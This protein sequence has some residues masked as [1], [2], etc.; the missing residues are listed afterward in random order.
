VDNRNRP[1]ANDV[2]AYL[3]QHPE[4]RDTTEGIADWWLLEQR[5]RSAVAE[6]EAALGALVSQG[7]VVA[8]ECRDGRTY[9]GLN[10][11]KEREVRRY[12]RTVLA[13]HDSQR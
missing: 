8:R 5:I 2:L 11:A 10:R 9:Y 4:A 6:V 1:L 3:V 13:L 7:F 12:L